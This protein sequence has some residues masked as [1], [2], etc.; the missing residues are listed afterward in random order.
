MVKRKQK[1]I[2]SRGKKVLVED[3]Q[4]NTYETPALIGRAVKQFNNILSLE[5]RRRGHFLPDM[6]SNGSMVNDFELDQDFLSV[7]VYSEFIKNKVTSNVCYLLL[8]NAIM[9]I[10]RI[11][12]TADDRGR[13]SEVEDDVVSGAKVCIEQVDLGLGLYDVG[14]R[15][16]SEFIIYSKFFELDLMDSIEIDNGVQV[17]NLR[18]D[19]FDAITYPGVIILNVSTNQRK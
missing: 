3:P 1:L 2:Q 5:S 13:I 8:T 9:N 6:I 18:L 15:P 12:K 19:S 7:G 11:S 10:K 14:Y 4:G 17:Q 16:K